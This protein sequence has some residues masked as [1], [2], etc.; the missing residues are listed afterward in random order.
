MLADQLQY[1]GQNIYLLI[2]LLVCGSVSLFILLALYIGLR[3]YFAH[4]ISERSFAEYHRRT[5]RADGKVYPPTAPGK[6]EE[7]QRL[8][9]KVY[10][11]TSDHH[12]CPE[13]YEPFW[14]REE[15]W[16]DPPAPPVSR[17]IAGFVQRVR[18]AIDKIVP[19]A[20]G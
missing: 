8:C 11:L 1:F 4:L 6:C 20:R 17:G 19:P 5:R 10:H 16:T 7:C 13:C 2:G 12:L 9:K 3:G 15:N 14:R 18:Q